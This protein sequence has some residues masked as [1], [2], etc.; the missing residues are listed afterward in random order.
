MRLLPG[1]AGP[2]LKLA[3]ALLA[4]GKREESIAEVN[5][6]IRLK[7]SDP[8]THSDLGAILLKLERPDEAIAEFREA[9]RLKPD[10]AGNRNNVAW[11]MVVSPGWPQR[12][13]DEAAEHAR[14]AVALMPKSGG[15]QNTLA[16][17]E[18]RCGRWA[19]SI[20]AAEQSMALRQGGNAWDWFFLAMAHG[21]KGEQDKAV[22]WFDKAVA[23]TRE[24][25]SQN[26]E[27]REFWTE[28]ATVLG[29]PG[30]DA[31]PQDSKPPG[32]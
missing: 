22:A 26:R 32:Q 13:Y 21:R 18:Y 17:A 7:P 28:A 10:D 25:D 11:T 19:E 3:S 20:T 9:I 16:L 2:H 31:A 8:G 4:Q 14:K 29:R 5:E 15:I 30:P 12:V 23:A 1:Q 6:A 27:L 24:K